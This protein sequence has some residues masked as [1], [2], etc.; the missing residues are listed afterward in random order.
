MPAKERLKHSMS[1]IQ[2]AGRLACGVAVWAAI[3]FASC[4]RS[5]L[6]GPGEGGAPATEKPLRVAIVLPGS[7]ADRGFNESAA[8]AAPV[9]RER[10]GAEVSVAEMTAPI[11]FEKTFHDYASAGFDVVVGHG[12]EFGDVAAK[13]APLYP[14]TYFFVTNNPV[15]TGANFK[16][17]QPRSQDS[18]YLAGIAAGSITQK[19]K[20]AAVGGFSFP[21]IVAQIEAFKAGVKS[22]RPDADFRSVYLNTFDDVEKGKEAA[23]A[24][25]A[26][27]VD[28]IYHIADSA[29][30]GVI[31]GA[32][33]AGIYAIGW[34]KDQYELAPATVATSQIVDQTKM[35]VSA[36]EAFKQGTLPEGVWSFGL[37]S[38]A[39][40]LAPIRLPDQKLASETQA[41]VD[42][43]KASIVS[44]EITVPFITEPS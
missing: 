25:S 1:R 27:G 20:V 21:V 38:G 5:P 24:L 23:L 18:A 41:K 42:A 40:G 8:D 19:G 44:G 28:V 32:R 4:A 35:I 43:A 22:V 16:G 12:F 29:G 10:L 31:S 33:Q 15:I 26:E 11:D 2:I 34:G 39:T 17:L 36:V 30:V 37:E 7:A 6:S 9:L 14:R 13:V 3:L